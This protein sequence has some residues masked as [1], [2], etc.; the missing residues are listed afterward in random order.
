[1]LLYNSAL[2]GSYLIVVSFLKGDSPSPY[3][4]LGL[5]IA[6]TGFILMKFNREETDEIDYV[7]LT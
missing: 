2:T 6:F 7:N 1:M 5:L 4:W 3:Y